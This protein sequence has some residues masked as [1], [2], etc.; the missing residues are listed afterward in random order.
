[1]NHIKNLKYLKSNDLHFYIGWSILILGLILFVLGEILW[2]YILPFQ[3]FFS[4]GFIITGAVVTFVPAAGRATEEE[5]DNEIKAHTEHLCQ[6]TSSAL[7]KLMLYRDETPT[8]VGRYVL[9]GDGII[10]RRGRRDQ[11]YRSSL[12][13]GAVIAFKKNA[14]YVMTTNLSLVDGQKSE[15]VV[16]FPYTSHPE[17]TVEE[18]FVDSLTKNGIR[19]RAYTLTIKDDNNSVSIPIENSVV[20]DELC[21]KLSRSVRTAK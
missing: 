18:S 7:E 14:L 10:V 17:A 12:Y 19:K 5:L 11:K 1:M 21:E 15:N 2:L 8:V 16:E 6:K 20:I 13:K 9:E 3:F 4:L